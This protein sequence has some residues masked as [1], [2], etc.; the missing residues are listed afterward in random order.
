MAQAS[1]QDEQDVESCWRDAR[2]I[3][4]Y[5]P[6]H[7]LLGVYSWNKQQDATQALELSAARRQT[8]RLFE[9]DFAKYWPG[10]DFAQ[11]TDAGW[12]KPWCCDGTLTAE[13]S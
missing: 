8:V 1:A 12:R 9:L 13:L 6:A 11:A 2:K 7:R 3:S 5:A 4:D 10:Q